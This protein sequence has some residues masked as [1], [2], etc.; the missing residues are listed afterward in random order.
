MRF[1]PQSLN[2][3]SADWAPIVTSTPESFCSCSSKRE[4]PFLA[5]HVA[6]RTHPEN[7]MIDQALV[8]AAYRVFQVRHDVPH[9]E[10]PIRVRA[11]LL[12]G[13]VVA[14]D[15]VDHAFRPHVHHFV[16]DVHVRA[17]RHDADHASR[18]HRVRIRLSVVIDAFQ[19]NDALLRHTSTLVRQ[20][21]LQWSFSLTRFVF[22][23][24]RGD[25]AVS[26][27]YFLTYFFRSASDTSDPYTFPAASAVTPSTP[28][29]PPASIC[30]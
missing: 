22:G 30:S 23:N 5:A 18:P 24:H 26:F 21:F 25:C 19:F 15:G 9:D 6:L 29:V 3:C 12:I 8:Q 2:A 27:R 1:A 7:Q 17:G 13:H 11:D 16:L 20:L 14:V 4:A 10:F 28:C